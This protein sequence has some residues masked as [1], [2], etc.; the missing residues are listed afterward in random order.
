MA[1]SIAPVLK[2]LLPVK[3]VKYTLAKLVEASRERGNNLGIWEA[4]GAIVRHIAE[5]SFNLPKE[6]FSILAPVSLQSS[7]LALSFS[8]YFGKNLTQLKDLE[9]SPE[10]ITS[11]L[12][13]G[14]S[15]AAH[16]Q[17]ADVLIKN[18]D[19]ARVAAE[20]FLENTPSAI[21][22]YIAP[23]L[24]SVSEPVE[25]TSQFRWKSTIPDDSKNRIA[26]HIG[27]I[28]TSLIAELPRRHAAETLRRAVCLCETDR[29]AILQQIANDRRRS[30]LTAWMVQLIEVLMSSRTL[31]DDEPR[32]WLYI[33]SDHLTRRFAEDNTLDATTLDFCDQTSKNIVSIPCQAYI[34][35]Y[36]RR[37]YQ[38][39]RA[40]N[41]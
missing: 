20:I 4:I 11:I 32:A 37:T 41:R 15:S 16:K 10:S 31:R 25:S 21:P 36:Y 30:T 5:K 18:R 35:T 3:D 23:L 14:V 13:Q 19:D 17:L 7:T 2:S 22:T 1:A 28:G 40:H 27:V 12:E 34:L 33:A 29:S 8:E 6:C 26:K 9:L 38:T 39:H 24:E